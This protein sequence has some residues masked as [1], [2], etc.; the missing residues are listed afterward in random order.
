MVKT[1]SHD[2]MDRWGWILS[3]QINSS[4]KISTELE[5]HLCFVLPL[6]L[7]STLVM[8]ETNQLSYITKL[9]CSC[10]TKESIKTSTT[11]AYNKK[12]IFY[13]YLKVKIQYLLL[14][15]SYWATSA[16]ISSTY[17]QL[18]LSIIF[19]FVGRFFFFFFILHLYF[20]LINFYVF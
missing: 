4:F 2:L 16:V 11:T 6:L 17:F 12:S 1:Y 18:S 20:K 13:I 9:L 14:L 10:Q 3:L 8:G 5:E 7:C 19:S 15:S